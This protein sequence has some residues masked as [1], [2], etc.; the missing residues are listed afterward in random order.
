MKNLFRNP[1]TYL[2]L[3]I[4]VPAI[5]F[6]VFFSNYYSIYRDLINPSVHDSDREAVKNPFDDIDSAG[7]NNKGTENNGN[8]KGGET[9]PPDKT[10]DDEQTDLPDATGKPSYG[11][12]VGTY[13]DKFEKLQQR[14]EDNVN[15]LLEQAKMDYA[16]NGS[17]KSAIFGLAPK[18]LGLV[19]KMEKQADKEFNILANDLKTELKNN[20]YETDIV[21]EIRD[22][23]NYYKKELR[24]QVVKKA[25]KHL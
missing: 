15:S 2:F 13:K 7:G 1:K 9:N 20:S 18:Y 8:P 11:Y 10:A 4:L 6:A 3:I 14:Q 12:I 17:K 19:N 5:V 21:K 23:Y 25:T 16:K 24:A 22:Y